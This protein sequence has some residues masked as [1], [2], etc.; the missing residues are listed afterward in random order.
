[1]ASGRDSDPIEGD[2]VRILGGAPGVDAEF[3]DQD[4]KV[5]G[6]EGGHR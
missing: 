5:R 2:A 6:G 4:E 1:M 3:V